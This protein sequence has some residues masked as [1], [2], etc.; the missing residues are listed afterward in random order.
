M[1]EMKRR[2]SKV[3]VE[4]GN[5]C[6][7]QCGFCPEVL[8]EK[9]FMPTDLFRRVVAEVSPLAEMICF[10]LMGEPLAHPRFRE[11]VAICEEAQLKIFLVSNGV[12]LREERFETLLS[13]AF[14]QVSFS[15]HSFYDNFP[16][17]DPEE[18]LRRIFAFAETALKDRPELFINFRLWNLSRLDDAGEENREVLSRIQRQFPFSWDKRLD[19]RVRKS[20]RIRGRLF[21]HFDTE[22]QWPSL[23]LPILGTVGKCHG[24]TS[25]FGI[26]VDGT[27]VPCCLDKEG[28]VAL[29]NVRNNS[30]EEVLGS[31]R[32]QRILKGFQRRELVEP[33][34]QRCQYIQ[35]FDAVKLRRDVNST[36]SLTLTGAPQ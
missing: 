30:L 22:F 9:Q 29:G 10:H 32:A 26:L 12:L 36:G 1:S 6:N 33:L 23:E 24:L 28:K 5:I 7:L 31:P 19:L 14:H 3:N 35:R 27:V 25:H 16:D 17:K 2:F 20:I 8:R 4:I 13:P 11:F 34:C 21:L 15:L 18:Y